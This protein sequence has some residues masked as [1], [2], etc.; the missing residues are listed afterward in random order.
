MMEDIEGGETTYRQGVLIPRR[1]ERQTAR[2]GVQHG[3]LGRAMRSATGMRVAR[4]GG[5][6]ALLYR[7]GATQTTS[8]GRGDAPASYCGIA[9]EGGILLQITVG[10]ARFAVGPFPPRPR[11]NCAL[12]IWISHLFWISHLSAIPYSNWTIGASTALNHWIARKVL[13]MDEPTWRR[14][15]QGEAR[16]R[17][18]RAW[19]RC[20]GEN[21][22]GDSSPG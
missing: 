18:S 13:G 7:R 22:N 2:I 16:T 5:R 1:S 11:T 14:V 8:A 20:R 10:G 6:E 3:S 17:T 19:N 9:E 12:G 21:S 4:E 15:S